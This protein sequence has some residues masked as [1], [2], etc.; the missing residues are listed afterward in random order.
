MRAK[1][2]IDDSFYEPSGFKKFFKKAMQAFSAPAHPF[3]NQYVH[4]PTLRRRAEE[5]HKSAL[6][7]Y[8]LIVEEAQF[9]SFLERN[10]Y[11]IEF[12]VLLVIKHMKKT[13][14]LKALT[15]KT[16]QKEFQVFKIVLSTFFC[17]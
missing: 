9:L 6:D 8:L 7:H 4:V 11:F 3:E 14:L 17:E 15:G 10:Y 16:K 5:I 12:E 2:F 13:K 1:K